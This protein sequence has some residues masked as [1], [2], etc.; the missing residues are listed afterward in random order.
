MHPFQQECAEFDR[1]AGTSQNIKITPCFLYFINFYKNI[2]YF[3]QFQAYFNLFVQSEQYKKYVSLPAIVFDTQNGHRHR[4]NTF[5]HNLYQ[6]DTI[7]QS[8]KLR[9]SIK[10]FYT[11]QDFDPIWQNHRNKCSSNVNY[12]TPPLS[13]LKYNST[14]KLFSLL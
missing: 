6:R 13:S 5:A 12:T 4:A 10:R 8:L 9:Y 2:R 7:K 3:L 1:T 11:Y 14:K